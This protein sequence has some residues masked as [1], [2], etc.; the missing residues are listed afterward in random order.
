M[1]FTV[2]RRN[3][4]LRA[5]Q[6]AIDRTA[7]RIDHQNF[8]SLIEIWLT[9]VGIG[10]SLLFNHLDVASLYLND[11]LDASLMEI[12][13]L[14]ASLDHCS[15]RSTRILPTVGKAANPAGYDAIV[16]AEDFSLT[17]VC[18]YRQLHIGLFTH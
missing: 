3:W 6:S 7:V 5:N 10:I 2:Y 12:K 14:R 18:P 9:P 4:T 11:D 15:H 8:A 16:W 17:N 13:F 1:Q